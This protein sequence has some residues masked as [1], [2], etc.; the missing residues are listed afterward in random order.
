MRAVVT[1]AT[2]VAVLLLLPA[3]AAAKDRRGA[4]LYAAN[5]ASCHGLNGQG[6][7][8][9]TPG[10]NGVDGQGPPLRGVGARAADFYLRTGYM[11][12]ANAHD[13]PNRKHVVFTE[14]EIRALVRYVASLGTGPPVPTPHPGSVS[15]GLRLFTDHCA[16]CHQAVAQGGYVTG[17]RVPPLTDATDRQIAE[18]VRVGPYLMPRFSTKAITPAQL[19]DIVA[20]VGYAKHPDDRGGWA[21]GHLGPWPEGAVTWLLA[22]AA[23]LGICTLLGRRLRT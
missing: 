23:L 21:I 19:N 20:Y 14:P 1:L 3:A 4:A 16:G 9:A 22:A 7:P 17:A 15:A 8:S 2:A 18:A 6:V 10:V 13:Q 12:L 11:P 5:C